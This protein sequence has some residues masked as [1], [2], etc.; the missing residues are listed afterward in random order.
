M[1]RDVGMPASGSKVGAKPVPSMTAPKQSIAL[2]LAMQV[3][4]PGGLPAVTSVADTKVVPAGMTSRALTP[5]AGLV[6]RFSARIR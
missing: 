1:M 4:A 6:P 2:A 3:K 5:K